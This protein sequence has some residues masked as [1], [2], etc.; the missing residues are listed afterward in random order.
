VAWAYLIFAGMLEIGFTTALRYV[1]GFTKPIPTIVFVIFATASLYFLNKA[2]NDIPLGTA[3]A[4]WTGI[5]AAGTVLLGIF[6]FQ[7][8]ADTWRLVFLSILI[9]SIVGLKLVSPH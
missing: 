2:S 3:Y 6:F 5:G 9:G 4:I 8:P 1:E 7:E